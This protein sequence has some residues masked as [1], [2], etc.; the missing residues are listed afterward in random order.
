MD[1]YQEKIYKSAV[2]GLRFILVLSI[3][4]SGFQLLSNFF[5]A[6]LYPAFKV[7]YENGDWQQMLPL[8]AQLSGSS[9]TTPFEYTMEQM[10]NVP[11]VVY[12]LWALLY[13]MSLAG[14]IMMWRLRKNGLHLYAIAQLLI[15]IVTLLFMGKSHLPLGDIMMTILFIVVYFINLRRIFQ[16]KPQE[17]EPEESSDNTEQKD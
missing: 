5:T 16:L 1:N 10:I 12:F 7:A 8:L 11:R 13:A 3:I 4:G 15:L 14:V 6:L 2:R 17:V 9:D